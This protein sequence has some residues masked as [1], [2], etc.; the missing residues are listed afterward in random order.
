MCTWPD[1]L[2][3]M[4]FTDKSATTNNRFRHKEKYN[5]MYALNR[6]SSQSFSEIASSRDSVDTVY[7]VVCT[8]PNFFNCPCYKSS[9]F[10]SENDVHDLLQRTPSHKIHYFH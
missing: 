3:V 2:N 9:P 1:Y 6:K 4:V 5:A 10:K 7:L 8:I